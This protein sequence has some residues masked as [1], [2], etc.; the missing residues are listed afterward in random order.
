MNCF[1]QFLGIRAIIF[2]VFFIISSFQITAQELN[3]K[4]YFG[5]SYTEAV[6]YCQSQKQTINSLF[7]QYGISPEEAIS[8]VFPEIIRYNRF[9][10]F[11]ETAALEVAYV[12]A[13]KNVADFSIGHFQMKPSFVESIER[14]LLNYKDLLQKFKEVIVYVPNRSN[15]FIRSERIERLKQEAWQLKYLA[16]FIRLAEKRFAKELSNKPQERLMIL[17]SAYNKGLNSNYEELKILSE[18]KT[19]PYG[20]SITGR[21]SYF[22]VANYFNTNDARLT[23]NPKL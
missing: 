17:S 1:F 10:D 13:G 21:F 22:D 3:P 12:Q 15:E 11:A 6:S 16:C 23:L 9:S 7:I 14:E 18:K 2:A 19:F 8:I 20:K 5:D 4:E